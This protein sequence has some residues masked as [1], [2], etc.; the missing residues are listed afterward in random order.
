VIHSTSLHRNFSFIIAMRDAKMCAAAW[1][2]NIGDQFSRLRIGFTSAPTLIAN[3]ISNC[4]KAVTAWA[5]S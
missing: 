2:T 4:L 1:A 3:A 5:R